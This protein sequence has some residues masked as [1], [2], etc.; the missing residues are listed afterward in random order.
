[1]KTNVK[2]ILLALG[3]SALALA[4]ISGSAAEPA[5]SGPEQTFSGTV[6]E[7]DLS[8]HTFKVEGT[9]LLSKTFNQGSA[10]TYFFLDYAAGTPDGLHAG[11]KVTVSYQSA[12]GVLVADR[13]VQQ[14][15]S[16]AGYVKS[17]DSQAHTVTVA[18]GGF[19]MSKQF[20]LPDDC[21]VVLRGNK[22]G[23]FADIQAGNYV[24]LTYET[25]S[26][27]P[28][29]QRIVQTSEEFTGSLT[30]IDLDEKTLKAKSLFGGSKSFKVGG[31]CIVDVTG[32]G[33]GQLSDL[34]PEEKLVFTYDQISGV[35]V[36][37]RI[38]PAKDTKD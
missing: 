22:P 37:N 18:S 12:D 4:S 13:V 26:G 1:M 10:C 17:I 9:F 29:V 33:S 27:L 6:K 8:E 19:S 30:A 7:V 23:T 11:Q 16:Y 25:P 32:K 31:H 36:V 34:K 28:T 5:A 14:P 38:A 2:R 24:T 15:L 35:N 20:H 21:H 3:V